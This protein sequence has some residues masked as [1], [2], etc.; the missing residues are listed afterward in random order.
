MPLFCRRDAMDVQSF[1]L[2]VVNNNCE[3]IEAMA[4]GPRLENRVRLSVVAL[5]VPLKGNR[6]IIERTFAVVTKEFST[7]GVSLITNHP[8]ALDEV[9]L[10]FR[11]EGDMQFVRGKAKHLNP[12]GAGFY[13]MGVQ[14]KEMAHPTDYPGLDSLDF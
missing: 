2:K 3:D 6:P 9:I 11:W 7:V 8:R 12:M 13:Q 4:E 5:V 1:M 14:L 10:G